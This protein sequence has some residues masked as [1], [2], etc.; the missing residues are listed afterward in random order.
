MIVLLIYTITIKLKFSLS[1]QTDGY[2]EGTHYYDPLSAQYKSRK[3]F[4][5]DIQHPYPNVLVI[6]EMASMKKG[7]VEGALESVENIL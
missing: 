3:D 2:I 5:Q 7:W 6:G 4:I 1:D